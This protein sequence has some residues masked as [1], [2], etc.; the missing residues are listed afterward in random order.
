MGFEFCRKARVGK[1]NPD[2]N[3]GYSNC[4]NGSYDVEGRGCG[5]GVRGGLCVVVV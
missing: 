1:N 3:G 2:S 5:F 4:R